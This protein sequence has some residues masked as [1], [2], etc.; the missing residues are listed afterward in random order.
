MRMTKRTRSPHLDKSTFHH[1]LSEITSSIWQRQ[2]GVTGWIH[3]DSPT[4]WEK[5]ARI[6]H[7]ICWSIPGLDYPEQAAHWP[8]STPHQPGLRTP[9]APLPSGRTSE[10]SLV[11]AV[12]KTGKKQSEISGMR[13]V[14]KA[15]SARVLGEGFEDIRD[16]KCYYS[17]SICAQKF[18]SLLYHR[19]QL[20]HTFCKIHFTPTSAHSI[21][22]SISLKIRVCLITNVLVSSANN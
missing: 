5:A 22:S 11:P 20:D 7:W 9:S 6:R 1:H 18:L 16:P 8:T 17:T 10:C 21:K 12:M 4:Q 19:E 2:T 3:Q 14:Y 15:V 13:E